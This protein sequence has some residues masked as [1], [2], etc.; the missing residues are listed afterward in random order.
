MLIG[1][2]SVEIRYNG[3]WW[4]SFFGGLF[5]AMKTP[6]IWFVLVNTLATTL[7]IFRSLKLLDLDIGK[8]QKFLWTTF[9]QSLVVIALIYIALLGLEAWGI[10]FVICIFLF[11]LLIAYTQHAEQPQMLHESVFN[12]WELLKSNF[13][14]VMGLQFTLLLM[15]AS[16][17]LILSAPLIYLYTSIFEWN[18]ARTD[19]WSTRIIH[20]IELF[21][22]IL[23]FDMILPILVAGTGY[24]YF[25]LKE[26]SGAEHLKKSILEVSE[27]YSKRRSR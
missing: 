26:L 18:F 13:G 12:A 21:I 6:S 16:F 19:V 23:A 11:M 9:I 14:Q 27:K 2:R 1:D 4:Q 3:E 25:S 10:L 5:Y 7:I 22:K 20:F 24:L 8:H 15:C 17:L